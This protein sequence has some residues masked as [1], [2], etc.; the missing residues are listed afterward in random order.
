HGGWTS[1][2]AVAALRAAMRRVDE[3]WPRFADS[4]STDEE[5][6]QLEALRGMRTRADGVVP[7]LIRLMERDDR[8]GA[9]EATIHRFCPVGDPLRSRLD[10]LFD[11]ELRLGRS[12]SHQ[13]VEAYGRGRAISLFVIALGLALSIAIGMTVIRTVTGSL[14]DVRRQVLELAAGEGDL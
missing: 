8:A 7:E 14:S 13:A 9:S 10:D 2:E 1:G 11:A 5:Q 6:R 12:A 4:R 3:G